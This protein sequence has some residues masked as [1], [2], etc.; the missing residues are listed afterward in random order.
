VSAEAETGVRVRLRGRGGRPSRVESAQLSDRILNVATKLFLGD[1]FGATSIEAVAKHAGISKRTFY[2]R[3]RGKEELFEAV[4]RRLIDRWMPPFDAALLDAPSLTEAL[5]RSAEYML[6][7]ALTAE[8]L[9]LHRMVVAEA[10]RF[11]GLAR[12][13]HELGAAAGVERIARHLDE[14]IAGGELRPMDA[15]FAAEQFILMTVTGPRRRALGLGKRLD[16]MELRAWID[17]TVGLF[18]DGCRRS[19]TPAADRRADDQP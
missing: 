11:P 14:R 5:R 4:V 7:V 1:G 12:I 19:E 9:A 13:L 8:G 3:F 6:D 10:D 16:S 17:N 2:H 18:L 15:R